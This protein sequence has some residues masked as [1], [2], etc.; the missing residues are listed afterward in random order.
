MRRA[1]IS[2]VFLAGCGATSIALEFQGDKDLN[3]RDGTPNSV[4]IRIYQL[5]DRSRFDRADFLD[6]QDKD[7]QVLE[8][9]LIQRTDQILHPG[10][11]LDFRQEMK[12]GVQFV[13]IAA[14][15]RDPSRGVWRDIIDLS[16]ETSVR[17]LLSDHK[18][19]RI[20]D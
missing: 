1:A 12:N 2:V 13:G 16:K 8:G 7:A 4:V 9:D 14:M 17:F 11:R 20:I 19:Q 15:F 3:P 5:A 18:L 6:L 10:T